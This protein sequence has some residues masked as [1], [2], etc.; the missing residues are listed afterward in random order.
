V[1]DR[2]I[3][4]MLRAATKAGIL[5]GWYAT[6]LVENR[7]YILNPGG[8][9]TITHTAAAAVDYCRMLWDGGI[10]PLYR[11]SEPQRIP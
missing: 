11:D 9:G 1:T 3:R 4:A 5:E 7:R 10:R 8:G 2:D 6:G